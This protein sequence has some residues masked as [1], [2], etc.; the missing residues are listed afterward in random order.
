[1]SNAEYGEFWRRVELWQ[2]L[3]HL[4]RHADIPCLFVG[5]WYDMYRE[6]Q[7]YEA[8]AKRN[9]STTRLLVG[10]WTHLNFHAPETALG[11][12]VDFGAAAR[13]GEEELFALQLEW[14]ESTLKTAVPPADQTPVRIF[15]MGG[16]DGHKTEAGKLF[17]NGRWRD[18]QDWPPGHHEVAFYLHPGGG[19][20]TS[21][22]AEA[23]PTR[24]VSDPQHP[25]PT[26]GGVHYFLQPDW[27][28]TVPYGAQDQRE[29][30]GIIGCSSD[31]PLSSCHDVVTF[32]TPPLDRDVEVTGTPHLV[33]WVSSS[34]PDTDFIARLIDVYPDSTDYPEGD[35]MNLCE[36]VIR[37]RYRDTR[38]RVSLMRA[39]EVYRV[40]IELYPTSNLFLAGHRIR[41]DIAS[42]SFPA[43]DVNPQSGGPL[44]D[45]AELPTAAVNHLYHDPERLSQL[46]LPMIPAARP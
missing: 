6:E 34:A 40:E 8:L 11:G 38:E 37:M 5:G 22:P 29:R 36:G 42:S 7:F 27:Q 45:T 26:I 25:V 10:P 19:L 23:A 44:L 3:E 21:Q 2:P 39:G 12:D 33:L 17:H 31:L 16:G 20:S 18:E 35:S 14:F 1:M 13:F 15:V 30:L 46:T 41:L 24:Y 43:Y 4:H 32:A 28:L 9:R